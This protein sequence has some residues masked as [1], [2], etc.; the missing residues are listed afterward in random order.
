LLGNYN[1]GKTFVLNC[2][3]GNTHLSGLAVST[4]GLSFKLVSNVHTKEKT[5]FLDTAGLESPVTV[6]DF[7]NESAKT[8]LPL[9][10]RKSTDVFL[11]TLVFA[12][13]DIFIV[14]LNHVSIREQENLAQLVARLTTF[15]KQNKFLIVLHN[16][17]DCNS[18][19]EQQQLWKNQVVSLYPNGTEIID[20]NTGVRWFNNNTTRHVAIVKSD[21]KLKTN[22]KTFLLIKNWIENYKPHTKR[23]YHLLEALEEH[24]GIHLVDFVQSLQGKVKIDYQN[25]RIKAS[26][27]DLKPYVFSADLGILLGSSKVRG[28]DYITIQG[29]TVIL[30]IPGMTIKPFR[31]RDGITLKYSLMNELQG[32]FTEFQ[33]IPNENKINTGVFASLGEQEFTLSVDPT[34]FDSEKASFEAYKGYFVIKIPILQAPNDDGSQVY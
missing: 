27:Q 29:R 30:E 7:E 19:E 12:M 9:A 5:I 17:K 8:L 10:D 1:A 14:V 20:S 25:N 11:Q 24:A 23:K 4:E 26:F 21:G 28:I 16:W 18:E 6:S 2:L 15:R 3:T 32:F 13:A 22:F 34:K 33:N 31:R